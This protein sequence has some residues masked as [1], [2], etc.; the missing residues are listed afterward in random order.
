MRRGVKQSRVLRG[1]VKLPDVD[2][3]ALERDTGAH[4][5]LFMGALDF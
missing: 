5:I 4:I 3:V 2:F 1:R